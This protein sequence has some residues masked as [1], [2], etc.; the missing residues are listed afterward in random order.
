MGWM[1]ELALQ[2]RRRRGHVYLM[3]MHGLYTI[4]PD[5][6]WLSIIFP[7]VGFACIFL[8]PSFERELQ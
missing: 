7:L 6:F 2:R 3:A 8:P 1:Q 4:V 5:G